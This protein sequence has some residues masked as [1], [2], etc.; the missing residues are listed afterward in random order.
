MYY[1]FNILD[2]ICILLVKLVLSCCLLLLATGW[3]SGEIKVFNSLRVRW[4]HSPSRPT[5]RKVPLRR[6][7]E[8]VGPNTA[9]V[10][11]SGVEGAHDR[12]GAESRRLFDRK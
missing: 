8:S 5:K 3:F 10:T 11:Q 1:L 6:D 9:K 2:I 12:A 4:P 7:N